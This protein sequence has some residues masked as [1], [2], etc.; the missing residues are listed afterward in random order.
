MLV[1]FSPSPKMFYPA[2]KAI[3]PFKSHLNYWCEHTF[4]RDISIMLHGKILNLRLLAR[5]SDLFTDI[6]DQEQT[7]RS[8]QF[9]FESTLS[10]IKLFFPIKLTLKYQN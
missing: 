9:G 4:D 5:L 2:I 7:L 6:V 8:V 3:L 1:A 10:D